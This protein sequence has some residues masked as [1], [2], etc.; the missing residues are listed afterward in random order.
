MRAFERLLLRLEKEPSCIEL[1]DPRQVQLA[2][3]PFKN[4]ASSRERLYCVVDWT[5]AFLLQTVAVMVACGELR[6]KSLGRGSNQRVPEAL[7]KR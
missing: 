1:L 6:K 5:R 3:P 4:A 2:K 7:T